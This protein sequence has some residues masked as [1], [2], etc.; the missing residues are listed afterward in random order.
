MAKMRILFTR[1]DVI[2][3]FAEGMHVQFA[4]AVLTLTD[5]S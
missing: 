3:F 1:N 4:E 2:L 5:S